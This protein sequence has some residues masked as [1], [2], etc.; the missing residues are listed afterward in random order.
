MSSD[1]LSLN[2][3]EILKLFKKDKDNLKIFG[4]EGIGIFGSFARGEQNIGSD[5]DILVLFRPGK[6]NYD[7]YYEL[8]EH[9]EKLLNRKVD[10]VTP[11]SLSPY[12]KPYVEKEMLYERL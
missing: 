7:V 6:K 9:L 10:I 2:A 11:E 8:H 12:I 4:L 3:N 5:V 1:N